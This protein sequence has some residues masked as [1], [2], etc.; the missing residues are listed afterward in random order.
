M[1]ITSLVTNA[2]QST[3]NETR[4][5]YDYNIL[6]DAVQLVICGTARDNNLPNCRNRDRVHD[7][8]N[9]KP[10]EDCPECKGETPPETS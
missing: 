8:G 9:D 7:D 2:L 6:R 10:D 3:K 4:I 1:T 5:P